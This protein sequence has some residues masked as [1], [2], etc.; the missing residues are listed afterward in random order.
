M[1]E[2]E[3]GGSEMKVKLRDNLRMLNTMRDA[4]AEFWNKFIN[5]T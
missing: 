3:Y 5:T 4:L 1:Q 2:P